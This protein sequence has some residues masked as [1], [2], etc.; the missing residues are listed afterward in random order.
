MAFRVQ[1][2]TRAR[3]DIEQA[4][5]WLIPIAP[6]SAQRWHN[7]LLARIQTLDVHPDRCP[8]AAEA[9]TLGIELRELLHGKRTG[10]FR[11]LFVIEN[12]SVNVLHVRRHSRDRVKH[13]DL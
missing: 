13:E 1:I 6:I 9:E 11:I 4:L 2:A 10:V 12:D 5:E 7:S 3:A 8:L